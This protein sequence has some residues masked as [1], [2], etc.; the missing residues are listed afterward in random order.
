MKR[1]AHLLL[2]IFF[3][4]V[5][6]ISGQA[7][8]NFFQDKNHL[9]VSNSFY[10][11][12]YDLR[13]GTWDMKDEEEGKLVLKDAYAQTVL[14][15]AG[16]KTECYFTSRG[17]KQRIYKKRQFQD[18]LG[19]GLELKIKSKG[20]DEPALN[21]IF[22]FYDGERFFLIWLELSETGVLDKNFQVKSL[23]PMET[24]GPSGGL[25]LGKNPAEMKILDNGS[26]WYLDFLVQ[27]HS[28]GSAPPFPASLFSSESRANWSSI[29]YDPES[30]RSAL[31]GFLSSE[32]GG[33][34]VATGFKIGKAGKDEERL[35]LSHYAGVSIYRPPILFRE[36]ISSEVLYLDFFAESPFSALEDYAEAIA[37]WNRVHVWKGDIPTGW[38]SWGEYFTKIDEGIILQNLEFAVK[39]FQPFGMR[40]FQVDDGYSPFWG[41]WDADPKRF[42]HGMK[43]LAEQIRSKGMIPG[44]WIAPFDADVDS[45][46][47]KE[48]PDWFLERKGFGPKFLVGKNLRVLDLSKPEAQEH[49][50]NTIRKYVNDWG[51]EWI[52]VDFAYHL[53]SYYEI[54]DGTSTVSEIYRQGLKIIKDEAGPGVFVLGVG[55]A[56]FNYGLVDGQRL[57]LDN[58]PVWAN[59]KSLFSLKSLG[60]A[61]GIV[62]TARITARRYWLNHH[63]WINH[64][65]L[66]F[67][68]ND[69]R[70]QL[71]APELSFDE[72][73][74][75]ASLVGMS[76]GIVKIG[77][78]MVEMTQQEVS[79]IQKLLP[80]YPKSGRPL[81]LFEKETPEI[82]HLPIRTDFDQWDIV[83]LFNWGKNWEGKKEI[84]EQTRLISVKLSAL[85]LDP[86]KKYLVFDFW[87]ERFLG[88]FEN[89]ISLEIA[90]RSV[91]V[92]AVRELKDRPW[93]LSY[94]RHFTQGAVDLKALKWD[95]ERKTLCAKLDT[96]PGF[97]YH[98][99][100]YAPDGFRLDR[101]EVSEPGFQVRNFGNLIQ[102]TFSARVSGSEAELCFMFSSN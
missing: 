35:G 57:S 2:I 26:N 96:V 18:Q 64:P 15:K 86:G 71:K 93:F 65:D 87:N 11:F 24:Q 47:F 82:W 23:A 14:L 22:R 97:E 99:Y 92:L 58:M 67:F 4:I 42:P 6:P 44:I 36:G 12:D 3:L 69:R 91:R 33:N 101:T 13:T 34:I 77:D 29:I 74:C 49:L 48:H 94:N 41:D 63:L 55:V 38:N 20:I 81:D 10:Q 43:W 46:I 79:V 68:N 88:I 37:G 7:G 70:F 52:K 59:Q 1:F 19:Q 21:T 75:F 30:G 85:G 54:G 102:V 73:L 40:Y 53:L 56:G 45:Q 16:T 62:P 76:G 83:G 100:I 61:Q 90:P 98:F 25:F 50:R 89:K 72:A 95:S 5:L 66:I 78:R 84:P 28:A 39:N 32:Q 80:V 17:D 60:F 51:Y 8:L 27:L 9:L 31:T